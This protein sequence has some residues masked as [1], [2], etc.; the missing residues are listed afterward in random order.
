MEVIPAVGVGEERVAAIPH[1]LHRLPRP[2]RGVEHQ[3]LGRVG[4]D[5]HAEAA[6]DV[7]GHDPQ[8]IGIDPGTGTN[9]VRNTG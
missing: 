9:V 8:A 5:L 1:P 2:A 6:A 7:P 4:E 3:R